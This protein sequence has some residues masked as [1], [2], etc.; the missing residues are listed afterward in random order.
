MRCSSIS[1]ACSR[2]QHHAL[3][4]CMPPAPEPAAKAAFRELPAQALWWAVIYSNRD[5]LTRDSPHPGAC[6]QMTL[7]MRLCTAWL[8]MQ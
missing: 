6:C 4:S 2:N 7:N 5:L 1:L 3:Y 8:T